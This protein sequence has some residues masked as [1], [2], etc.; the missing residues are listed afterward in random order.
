MSDRH[1]GDK[2]LLL[3]HLAVVPQSLDELLT[4]RLDAS[5]MSAEPVPSPVLVQSGMVA[6]DALGIIPTRIQI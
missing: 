1:R 4:L 6:S 3:G 5:C 2:I